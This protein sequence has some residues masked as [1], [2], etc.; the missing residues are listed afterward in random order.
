[1]LKKRFRSPRRPRQGSGWLIRSQSHKGG[2]MGGSRPG[3]TASVYSARSEQ[4]KAKLAMRQRHEER[5]NQIL[6]DLQRRA[7][8]GG[9]H[10]SP[11]DFAAMSTVASEEATRQITEQSVMGATGLLSEVAQRDGGRGSRYRLDAAR[12]SA[13]CS[14]PSRRCSCRT[15]TACPRARTTCTTA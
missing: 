14:T 12:S 2:A 9:R 1:M 13:D 8:V 3:S 4:S 6:L 11:E 5:K 15:F 7:K 10:M